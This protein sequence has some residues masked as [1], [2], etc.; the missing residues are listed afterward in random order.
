MTH[1]HRLQHFP[2]YALARFYCFSCGFSV[3][4]LHRQS[5]AQLFKGNHFKTWFPCEEHLRK[6]W[7]NPQ[8]YGIAIVPGPVSGRLVI[9]DFDAPGSFDAWQQATRIDAPRVLS[10]RG[11][12]VY[13]RLQEAVKGGKLMFRGQLVGDVLVGGPV[14]A[15]PSLHPSGKAYQWV[16]DPRRIALF[17]CL[18]DLDVQRVAPAGSP[19]LAPRRPTDV[20][21]KRASQ[22]I[23][24][25]RRYAQ[26]AIAGERRKLLQ[27]PV[28]RRNSQL[29]ES[30]L[31][32]AKYVSI[33]SR[34]E[35]EEELERIGQALNCE[36]DSSNVRAT[37]RSGL[38]HGLANGVL[39]I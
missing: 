17:P 36:E 34:Q 21:S 26:A 19:T 35:I 27:T 10:N 16:G 39:N 4:P 7:C 37:V 1:L 14:P 18:A 30:A 24:N 22:R 23:R 9:L 8:G 13:V 12:H 6:W 32:L 20:P 15:P 33:L 29:Y 2:T 28:G 31:K 3:V 38:E 11:C 25:P 5:K